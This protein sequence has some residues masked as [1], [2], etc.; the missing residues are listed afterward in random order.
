MELRDTTLVDKQQAQG[1]ETPLDWDRPVRQGILR[2]LAIQDSDIRLLMLEQCRDA[3]DKLR[4]NW[5]RQSGTGLAK[6][7]AMEFAALKI[8]VARPI[9]RG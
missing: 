8:D 6:S 5:R 7:P 4:P 3:V 2:L 1:P 9:C